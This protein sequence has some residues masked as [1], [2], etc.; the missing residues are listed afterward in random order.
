M[1]YAKGAP[2][3]GAATSATVLRP[4]S[5]RPDPVWTLEHPRPRSTILP[6]AINQAIDYIRKAGLK[7]KRIAFEFGFMPYDASKLLREA[8]PDADY[9]DALFV[10]RSAARR[11]I[12][13]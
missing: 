10:L 6:D 8:F 11:E 4:S 3:E 5:S 2:G 1:V 7:T 13:R 9:V 12:R